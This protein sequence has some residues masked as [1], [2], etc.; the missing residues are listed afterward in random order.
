MDVT[1]ALEIFR[2]KTKPMSSEYR[3]FCFRHRYSAQLKDYEMIFPHR[4]P[5]VTEQRY[6]QYPAAFRS[7]P[8]P[9]RN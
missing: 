4:L 9:R 7:S 2:L 8:P 6:D 3:K 1:L 5:I